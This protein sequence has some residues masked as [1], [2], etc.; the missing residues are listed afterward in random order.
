MGI[1]ALL[2]ITFSSKKGQGGLALWQHATAVIITIVRE[3]K[4]SG[5]IN[6]VNGFFIAGMSYR[7][8]R[9]LPEDSVP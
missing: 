8:L 5:T 1:W 9:Q 6:G 3:K 7:N 2:S 4:I